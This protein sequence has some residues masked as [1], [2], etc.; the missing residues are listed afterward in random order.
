MDFQKIL[1]L[2]NE[3]VGEMNDHSV[4]ETEFKCMMVCDDCP[5]YIRRSNGES[6]CLHRIACEAISSMI[7]NCDEPD[8]REMCCNA[9]DRYDPADGVCKLD[10]E[11]RPGYADA[12][13]MFEPETDTIKNEE[14]QK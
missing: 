14:V 3:I 11:S 4:Y 9:C 12:C 1:R 13:G 8:Y 6:E 2:L 5:C 10:G 7:N